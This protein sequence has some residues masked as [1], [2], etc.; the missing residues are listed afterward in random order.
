MLGFTT[1]MKS[2]QNIVNILDI[3]FNIKNGTKD[4]ITQYILCKTST[5]Q[6]SIQT[7]THIYN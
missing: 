6:Y 7:T 1:D 3:N 2:K 4:Q 5:T